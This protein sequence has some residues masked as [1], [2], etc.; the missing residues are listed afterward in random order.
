MLPVEQADDVPVRVGR[1][2]NDDITLLEVGMADT[3]MTE[4]QTPRDE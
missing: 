2:R 4:G 3:E 1:P